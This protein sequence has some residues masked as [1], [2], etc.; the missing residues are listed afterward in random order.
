MQASYWYQ[1]FPGFS[2]FGC[3]LWQ[4][5]EMWRRR[6]GEGG[7]LGTRLCCCKDEQLM[8]NMSSLQ[9]RNTQT[10]SEVLCKS[11]TAQAV[12]LSIPGLIS[13]AWVNRRWGVP[14]HT[15]K[16]VGSWLYPLTHVK[17]GISL[18]S[19]P[20]PHFKTVAMSNHKTCH[21]HTR[22]EEG[23][24]HPCASLPAVEEGFLHPCASL[25]AVAVKAY[26]DNAMFGVALYMLL[27]CRG[28]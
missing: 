21:G 25:P 14:S 11:S 1:A 6:E 19:C 2:H 26:G 16:A 28:N 4:R 5:L 27:R 10:I 22:R 24:L 3:P 8:N 20:R 17:G 9:H 7:H 18:R 13:C 12:F 15:R 23:F